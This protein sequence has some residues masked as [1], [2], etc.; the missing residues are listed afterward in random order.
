MVAVQYYRIGTHLAYDHNSGCPSGEIN[1][2]F[3][4]NGD[5]FPDREGTSG[6]ADDI[7]LAARAVCLSSGQHNVFRLAGAHADDGLFQGRE[8]LIFSKD[9]RLR[10]VFV[11]TVKYP[12]VIQG[13]D[14]SDGNGASMMCMW[15]DD[16]L[17]CGTSCNIIAGTGHKQSDHFIGSTEF[18]RMGR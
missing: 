2:Q 3:L 16:L 10:A 12:A 4:T 11:G 9:E 14:I 8:E 15:H 6:Y 5:L 7:F 1:A 18:R 13:A 17:S